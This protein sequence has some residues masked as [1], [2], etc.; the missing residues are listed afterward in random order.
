[1]RRKDNKITQRLILAIAASVM[2]ISVVAQAPAKRPTL[3]VGIVVNGLRSD[4]IELLKSHFGENGIKRLLNNGA[5]I[6]NVEYGTNIDATAATA[7]LFSG[8][9]ASINGIPASTVYDI[10]KK[11]SYPVLLDPTKIGNYTDE[12]YSPASL[13]TSTLSDEI[14]IE[15][16]GVGYVYSIAPDAQQAIIMAGHA[17]NSAFWINDVTGKW[18][19]TTYYKDVP[20]AIQSRNLSKPLANRLDTLTWHPSLSL[21]KYPDLPEYKQHYP[22]RHTFARSDKNRYKAYKES[23]PVNAEITSIATDYIKTMSL[24]KRGVMDMLNIT[25]T[26]TPY[27]YTRNGDNRVELMDSYLKLD[28]EL[29]N[30]FRAIDR[31]VGINNS[32]IFIAGTPAPTRTRREDEKWGIPSGEFS[33]KK[34]T[35]LLNMYLMAIYGNGNWV[36]GFHN[37]QI[38]LNHKL[39]KE[40]NKDIK[41]IRNNAADFVARMS[42]VSG[43]FTI[44]QI[45]SGQ[46]G[47]QKRINTHISYAGDLFLNISPG[48]EIIENNGA[49]EHRSISHSYATS[50]PIF[51]LSPAIQAQKIVRPVSILDIAPTISRILRIRSPNATANSPI[52]L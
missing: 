15:Y 11:H 42:G 16:D 26:V 19:T 29:A 27:S 48:W 49:N 50:A 25:Y 9:P 34:A 12:T 18:A 38:Y 46:A 37:N 10:E 8:A 51:I 17:G 21:D 5:L 35:S 6:E 23:A 20:T 4:Y 39:I 7:M 3:V 31:N 45:L 52:S 36:N 43:V 32:L 30:L 33:S 44:D 22:F 40:R 2:T 13:L 14:R 28:A 24:G 47:E 41:E 1:M